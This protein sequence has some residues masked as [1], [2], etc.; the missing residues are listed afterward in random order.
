[1]TTLP[2]VCPMLALEYFNLVDAANR[3]KRPP[4]KWI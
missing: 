3:M 1:M 4:L 2:F